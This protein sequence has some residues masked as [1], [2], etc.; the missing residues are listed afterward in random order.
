MSG[1]GIQFESDVSLGEGDLTELKIIVP[2]FPYPKITALCEVVRTERL[3]GDTPN[4]F[5]IALKFLVINEND[6]DLLINYIFVKER[7]YLR[8]KKEMAS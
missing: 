2:L 6:R 1:A 4:N 7:E 3:G 5:T 8:Q